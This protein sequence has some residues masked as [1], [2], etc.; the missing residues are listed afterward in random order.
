MGL[1]GKNFANLVMYTSFNIASTVQ[2]LI[3]PAK[4]RI[5]REAPA[6]KIIRHWPFIMLNRRVMER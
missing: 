1:L 6:K 3:R 2:V 5:V 4:L